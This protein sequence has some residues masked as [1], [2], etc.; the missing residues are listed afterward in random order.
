MKLVN[1]LKED[2]EHGFDEETLIDSIIRDCKPFLKEI[3]YEVDK[4]KLYRGTTGSDSIISVKPVFKQYA[5]LNDRKPMNSSRVMHDFLNSWFEK[6]YG[7]PFRNGVFVT[8][9]MNFAENYGFINVIFPIGEFEY[10]WS[11]TYE[12]L[13]VHLGKLCIELKEKGIL[14]R[15]YNCKEINKDT[16]IMKYIL[17][18][19]MVEFKNNDLKSAIKSGHEIMLW[20]KSYYSIPLE[21]LSNSFFTELK[22][23]AKYG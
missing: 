20:C 12:D 17:D 6:N 23:I 13:Y 5:R 9:D 16:K 7:H 2:F 4:Y 22:L 1:I 18:N 21:I 8:G 14:Q 11:P 10:L 3:D 15:D 19:K